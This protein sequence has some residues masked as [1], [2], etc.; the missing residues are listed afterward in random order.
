M[1]KVSDISQNINLYTFVIE[2]F[3]EN[4]SG[5]DEVYPPNVADCEKI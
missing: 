2:K 5:T 1:S 3:D 4:T